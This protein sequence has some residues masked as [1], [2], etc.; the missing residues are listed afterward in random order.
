MA[1]PGRWTLSLLADF[2][3]LL[4]DSDRRD[5][6]AMP[7]HEALRSCLQGLD[8]TDD[9]RSPDVRGCLLRR[10]TLRVREE[11]SEPLPG[12]ALAQALSALVWILGLGGLVSGGLSMAGYL[13]Y[14]GQTPINVGLFVTFWVGFQ[15]V[16]LA[17]GAVLGRS[18]KAFPG[19]FGRLF[20]LG[21]TRLAG[22]VQSWTP[23]ARIEARRIRLKRTS[24]F[25][26]SMAIQLW[27]YL[28]WPL[29]SAM[30][31]F[32]AAFNLGAALVFVLLVTTRDLAFGWQSTLELGPS[33]VHDLAKALAW[34]WSWFHG[35][36]P[37]LEQVEGSRIVLKD[38]LAS[39]V[40]T[41][42]TAWWPFLLGCI[43]CYGLLPR[44]GV[45][46]LALIRTRISLS[47]GF[48]QSAAAV[49]L[50]QRLGVS[51]QAEMS[52]G[53]A[54]P[55][56]RS[57]LED[58]SNQ[59]T[60][61]KPETVSKDGT[62]SDRCAQKGVEGSKIPCPEAETFG[63]ADPSGP[64]WAL[65][66]PAELGPVPDGLPYFPWIGPDHGLPTVLTLSGQVRDDSDSAAKLVENTGPSD[67]ILV[68][69]AWQPPIRENLRLL[70]EL[71]KAAGEAS[72]L[73]VLL[74][75]RPR[76]GSPFTTPDPDQAQIWE[77]ITAGLG[78]P[79]LEVR[80]HES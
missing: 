55:V 73:T 45:L 69:E 23:G 3:Y 33:L 72:A 46:A 18:R 16:L 64:G 27:P 71:S 61:P 26:R 13:A 15:L 54:G 47:R 22:M 57:N 53:S 1:D 31:F 58:I 65:L 25:F 66:W 75:G 35:A 63:N 24:G 17:A 59:E 19:A 79:N 40:S 67:L 43:F 70:E 52:P 6:S 50:A 42:L 78:R 48:P 34:P 77:D 68:Q 8:P 10:W 56:S 32:G 9:L 29:T 76:Q 7:D 44:L 30:Q 80:R 38:G 5:E 37:S 20:L 60:R 51:A 12:A 11:R 62:C 49:R 2:W 4:Q 36:W 74:V 41:D 14:T 28:T 21:L 39:L